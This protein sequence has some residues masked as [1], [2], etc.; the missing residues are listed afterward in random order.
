MLWSKKQSVALKLSIE[1]EFRVMSNGIDEVLWIRGIL[2]ELKF[3]Y[4]EPIKV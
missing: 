1:V 3:P 4:E 2:Q